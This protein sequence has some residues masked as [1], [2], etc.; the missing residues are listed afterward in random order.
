MTRCTGRSAREFPAWFRGA[1]PVDPAFACLNDKTTDYIVAER[2]F[3]SPIPG[4]FLRNIRNILYQQVPEEQSFG[5][6]SV[7]NGE[8]SVEVAARL[9]RV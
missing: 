9:D 3:I 2:Y 6:G 8:V 1:L 4:Y 5:A 7:K